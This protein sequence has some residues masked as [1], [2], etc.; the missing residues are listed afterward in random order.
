MG[1]PVPDLEI[2]ILDEDFKPLPAGEVGFICI[3]ANP[4]RPVGIFDGYLK[5]DA[6]ENR[7]GVPAGLVQYR[8]QGREGQRRLLSLV[9]Q[10]RRHHPAGYRIGPFE[11]ESVLLEHPAV[12]ESAVSHIR[13]R[14]RGN[15]VKA[16]VVLADGWSCSPALAGELQDYVK[17]D[18]AVQVS[19]RDRL[20]P[21]LPK[22]I[23][24][25]VKRAVL[26]SGS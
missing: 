24:G 26:R 22:T 6:E 25:K 8:G 1:K 7:E 5:E 20:R 19:A 15:I 23:S 18:R 9:R 21:R 17:R 12:V 16:F 3:K 13:T 4:V 10:G 2:D 14:S 11:V